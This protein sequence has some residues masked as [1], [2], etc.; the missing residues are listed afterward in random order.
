MEKG[1]SYGGIA[2]MELLSKLASGELVGLFIGGIS[3]IGGLLCGIIGIIAGTWQK[4]RRAEIAAALKQEM[5]NRGMSAEDIRTVLE[6]GSKESRRAMRHRP[7]RCPSG[8][9]T[10]DNHP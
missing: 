4:V 7:S 5:L 2:M 1:S 10:A 9:A 8:T 3:I 6:A